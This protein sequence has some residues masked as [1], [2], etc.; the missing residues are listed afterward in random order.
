MSVL[1]ASRL[2]AQF[3]AALERLVI[4][5]RDTKRTGGTP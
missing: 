4:Q 5:W 3:L 1:K 2:M